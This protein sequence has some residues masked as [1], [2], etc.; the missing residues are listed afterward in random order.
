MQQR[1]IPPK[2]SVLVV[3]DQEDILGFITVA[4]EAEG[5]EVR[6]A[7]DGAQALIL[8]SERPADVL[9]TDL[10]M[11]VQEGFETI[12]RCKAR[13]PQTRIVAMSAGATG[14]TRH[15]YLVSAELVGVDAT[16]HKPFSAD[17]LLDMVRRVLQ[18][19]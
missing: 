13:Y 6:T 1:S 11:P 17:E 14:R 4:L 10:F 5:Y 2:A 3:D 19:R 7:P 8:L 16:L 12:D 18:T 15:D 9:I